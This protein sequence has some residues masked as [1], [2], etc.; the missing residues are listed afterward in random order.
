M[1]AATNTPCWLDG[2][3]WTNQGGS[4]PPTQTWTN[5]VT[6]KVKKKNK[7]LINKET[8]TQR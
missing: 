1:D 3:W 4:T 5:I 7:G 6:K 2:V 8:D